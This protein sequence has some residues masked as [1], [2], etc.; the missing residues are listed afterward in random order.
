MALNYDRI[1]KI[2]IHVTMGVLWISVRGHSDQHYVDETQLQAHGRMCLIYW[3]NL[4]Y[5]LL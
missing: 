3:C 5:I 1:C 4:K 2:L